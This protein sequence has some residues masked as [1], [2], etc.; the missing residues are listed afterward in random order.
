[1]KNNQ[2]IEAVRTIL[3]KFQDGYKE[4][5]LEEL[6][7]FL[8]LFI[9][10]D[11]VELIGIGASERGGHEWFEGIEKVREIIQS[12]WTY[13]GNV[14]ID[15]AGAKISVKG[16]VAWLT[17]AGFLEQTDTFDKALPIYLEQMTEILNEKEKDADERLLEASHYG[18]RRLR[19][20]LKGVGY[21]WPFVISAVLQQDAGQWRF[22]TIHWSMPV[23]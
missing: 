9:S 22:H 11:D 16:D 3:Q 7:Q 10:N 1:M 4:R 15:V 2:P 23:D 17:T 6:D 19:E 14:E 21:Q 12:D 20:R 18:V 5:N 8:A 13:W